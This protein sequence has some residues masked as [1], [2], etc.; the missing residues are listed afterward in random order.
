MIF[1]REKWS[2]IFVLIL[3]HFGQRIKMLSQLDK[4]LKQCS[5]VFERI[6]YLNG[7]PQRVSTK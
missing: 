6:D 1:L 7:L 4:N 2:C 5:D 3:A